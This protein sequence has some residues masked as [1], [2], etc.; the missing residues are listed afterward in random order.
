M[1]LF[2]LN[3]LTSV[4]KQAP[5]NDCHCKPLIKTLENKL[6]AAKMEMRSE[7]HT[8]Q[9]EINCRLGRIEQKNK[10]QV[11][12]LLWYWHFFV[13]FTS[14]HHIFVIPMDEIGKTLPKPMLLKMCVLETHVFLFRLKFL[15]NSQRSVCRLK[16]W[17]VIIESIREPPW[18][19]WRARENRY[20]TL[21][22]EMH[23]YSCLAW[24]W[25][26]KLMLLCF[27]L[28]SRLLLAMPWKAGACLRFRILKCGCL[29]RHNTI[30][31]CALHRW[32]SLWWIQTLRVSRCC[33]SS[34]RRAPARWP[35]MS[36]C[37]P[38]QE[39]VLIIMWKV[40][41]L[42]THVGGD[43]LR[44]SWTVLQVRKKCTDFFFFNKSISLF[45]IKISKHP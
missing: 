36:M 23:D 8:V 21:R 11:C 14:T 28:S 29:Q 27:Y 32:I 44:W 19:A 37:Y 12:R 34:L 45:P 13:S 4:C 17:S 10:H 9:E 18:N 20:N 5:V 41:D 22:E 33:R 1:H 35:P 2:V 26:I 16:G 31:F 39:H 43:T 7:I 38:A 6:K 3:L 24:T 15:R 42:R 25:L 30:N 40:L